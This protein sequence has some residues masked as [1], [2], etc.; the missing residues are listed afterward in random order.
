MRYQRLQRRHAGFTLI[1]LLVVIAIIAVLIGLLLPAVQ[2]V[3]EAAAQQAGK[4]SIQSVLCPP[5]LCDALKVGATLRYPSADGLSAQAVLAAGLMAT[6]TPDLID[7]QMPFAVYPAATAGLADPVTVGF[8]WDAAEFAGNSFSL[9]GSDYVDGKPTFLIRRDD[10][11]KLWTVQ[12]SADGSTVALLA[13]AAALDE[14]APTWLL[15]A[16]L[17][18]LGTPAA[19]RR[20]RRRQELARRQARAGGGGGALCSGPCAPSCSPSCC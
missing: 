12:A 13:A 3:R 1:E 7:Q 2:K 14:P 16:A 19:L 10:D 4:D 18:A 11:G 6:F 8:G 17:G 5:P 20:R 9:L 15:A